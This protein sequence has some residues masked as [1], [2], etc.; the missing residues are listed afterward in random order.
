MDWFYGEI[1]NGFEWDVDEKDEKYNCIKEW[2]LFLRKHKKYT[3]YPKDNEFLEE[4]IYYDNSPPCGLPSRWGQYCILVQNENEDK[5]EYI[6]KFTGEMKNYEREIENFIQIVLVNMSS[7][8]SKC[9][10]LQEGC[11]NILSY[12]DKHIRN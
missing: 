1:K 6:W 5:D 2:I 4:K 10:I 3:I 9:W 8:I 7:N 12:S 11:E